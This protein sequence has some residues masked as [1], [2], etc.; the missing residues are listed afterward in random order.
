MNEKYRERNG[1]V[2]IRF[3]QKKRF[4]VVE[5]NRIGRKRSWIKRVIK[6]KPAIKLAKKLAKKHLLAFDERKDI[7]RWKSISNLYLNNLEEP[8]RIVT[9][10][11]AKDLL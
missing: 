6:L 3:N 11:K 10:E 8:V 5:L 4:F 1:S 9:E 7:D 2:V